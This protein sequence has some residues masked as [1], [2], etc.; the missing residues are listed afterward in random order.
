M[1]IGLK[2]S[3]YKIGSKK[4][5]IRALN[6]SPGYSVK[7]LVSWPIRT[8]FSGVEATTLLAIVHDPYNE[9]SSIDS[10]IIVKEQYEGSLKLVSIARYMQFLTSIKK[11]MN[12]SITFVKIANNENIL[13]KIRY[14]KD[15]PFISNALQKFT[16]QMPTLPEYVYAAYLVPVQGLKEFVCAV[17]QQNG[18]LLY[19]HDF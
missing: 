9:L 10:S 11:I 1:F 4:S 18:E 13:C 14:K 17:E 6:L 3:L 5:S 19:I 15:T 8:M 2:L 16:W 7:A 12:S